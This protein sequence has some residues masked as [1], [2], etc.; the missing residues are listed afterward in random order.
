M[1]TNEIFIE[2]LKELVDDKMANS[3]MSFNAI[4][5]EIGINQPTLFRYLKGEREPGIVNLAKI[6]KYF[7]ES[8]D[9]L[10]GLKSYEKG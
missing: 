3:K 10:L 1:E 9:W 5:K 7:N 8:A 2:R 4:A 6:A